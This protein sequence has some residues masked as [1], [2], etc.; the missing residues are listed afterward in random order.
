VTER[1]PLNDFPMLGFYLVLFVGIALLSQSSSDHFDLI[2]LIGCCLVVIAI[3]GTYSLG[4]KRGR[5]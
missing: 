5:Q 3:E 1:N 2:G 4:K